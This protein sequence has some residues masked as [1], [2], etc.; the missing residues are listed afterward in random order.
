MDPDS[1]RKISRSLGSLDDI[2]VTLERL[3]QGPGFTRSG[4]EE[5]RD[6]NGS[7]TTSSN[8]FDA[9]DCAESAA[10]EENSERSRSAG[11]KIGGD[12]NDSDYFN[13]NKREI[14]SVA[15]GIRAFHGS[16]LNT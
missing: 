12:D 9:Y 6:A 15:S 1:K 11:E 16:V 13:R 4:G 5:T 14:L 8:A 2:L 10:S 7:D 3:K